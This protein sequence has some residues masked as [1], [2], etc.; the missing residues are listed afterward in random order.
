MATAVFS[1]QDILEAAFI[2]W[3]STP[4]ITA[5]PGLRALTGPDTITDMVNTNVVFEEPVGFPSSW[6]FRSR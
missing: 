3:L 2:L 6:K 4:W 1:G 5:L